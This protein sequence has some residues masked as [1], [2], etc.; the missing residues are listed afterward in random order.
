MVRED[1]WSRELRE[2]EAERKKKEAE[3][4]ERKRKKQEERDAS[5]KNG[6]SGLRDLVG[7]AKK[8]VR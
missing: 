8:V 5:D 1:K 4:A 3:E 7:V 2:K 6:S